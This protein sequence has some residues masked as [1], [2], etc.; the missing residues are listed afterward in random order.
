MF[1]SALLQIDQKKI[2]Y[3]FHLVSMYAVWTT[4]VILLKLYPSF[5]FDGSFASIPKI[6]LHEWWISQ[7]S[8]SS[9]NK[10]ETN[11]K[12]LNTKYTVRYPSNETE[13]AHCFR[14][15][16]CLPIYSTLMHMYIVH[17]FRCHVVYWNMQ[18]GWKC[19]IPFE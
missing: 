1:E 11:K 4:I 9:T 13:F 8:D 12:K 5:V 16:T 3:A 7:S 2:K 14:G 10:I 17:T 19:Q 6:V 15:F 18:Y